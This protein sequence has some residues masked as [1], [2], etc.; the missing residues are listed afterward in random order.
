MHCL[1]HVASLKPKWITWYF[2]GYSIFGENFFIFGMFH[3]MTFVL[4]K[5]IG[6]WL[7]GRGCFWMI[8]FYFQMYFYVI[9][10]LR[11]DCL[12]FFQITEDMWAEEDRVYFFL[13][14]NGNLIWLFYFYL[15]VCH[16]SRVKF[17]SI[18]YSRRIFNFHRVSFSLV[19][20]YTK[21]FGGVNL[22]ED[23]I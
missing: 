12:L 7:D 13:L 4:S 8:V 22:V 14:I 11:F 1:K 19:T 16:P 3:F 9:H 23:P 17:R 2:G 18:S 6:G 21:V 10:S 5:K 15:A 20:S